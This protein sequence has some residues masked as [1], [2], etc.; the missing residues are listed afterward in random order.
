MNESV[1]RFT[2]CLK[3]KY[4]NIYGN[5]SE[6]VDASIEKKAQG[7]INCVIT[8]QSTII[9]DD[10]LRIFISAENSGTL[11]YLVRGDLASSSS[12]QEFE[13]SAV[14]NVKL[15]PSEGIKY[16]EVKVRDLAGNYCPKTEFE[17]EIDKETEWYDSQIVGDPVWT[18][19]G[20]ITIQNTFPYLS[21]DTPEMRIYGGVKESDQTFEWVPYQ[22]EIEVELEPLN[23]HRFVFVKFRTND[24]PGSETERII[25]FVY[26]RP[27]VIL[28]DRSSYLDVVLSDIVGTTGITITGCDETYNAVEFAQAYQCTNPEA[29][30]VVTYTFDNDTT[31]VQTV[32]S[33]TAR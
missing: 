28:Y 16:I 31:L 21:S 8:P 29:N 9:D 11:E 20:I 26:L 7:P 3:F 33:N 25:N 27:Y 14:A 24:K 6:L 1:R 13:D 2:P 30:V 4:R 12:Y 18:D 10:E 5:E 23:G 32:A 17:I 19:E 15:L 22:E